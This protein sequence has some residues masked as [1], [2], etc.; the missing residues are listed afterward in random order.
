MAKSKSGSRRNSDETARLPAFCFD[1]W[2]PPHWALPEHWFTCVCTL[3]RPRL[4]I[5]STA[6]IEDFMVELVYV[7]KRGL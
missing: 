7:I 5:K 2:E 4:L 1:T 6:R 3:A